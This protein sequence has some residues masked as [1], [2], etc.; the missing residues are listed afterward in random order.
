MIFVHSADRTGPSEDE[1]NFYRRTRSI[2][3]ALNWIGFEI[4]RG[5]QSKT[6]PGSSQIGKV[7]FD[8][9]SYRFQVS[10]QILSSFVSASS[11]WDR[12]RRS[13]PKKKKNIFLP[14]IGTISID[15]TPTKSWTTE[16]K[17]T[18][19][20]PKLGLSV[21]ELF[22]PSQWKRFV[23][24]LLISISVV[25]AERFFFSIRTN[26]RENLLI[27]RGKDRFC[28]REGKKCKGIE[29]RR[30][31]TKNNSSLT[32]PIRAFSKWR[33]T[34][35]E[36]GAL[37]RSFSLFYEHFSK[38][39]NRFS[40]RS[41]FVN[42]RKKEERSSSHLLLWAIRR[43]N[44]ERC[45]TLF[46][47]NG[48]SVEFF[49]QV[50]KFGSLGRSILSVRSFRMKANSKIWNRNSFHRKSTMNFSIFCLLQDSIRCIDKE[51]FSVSFSQKGTKE[52]V[53]VRLVRLR[54]MYDC[55]HSAAR[56]IVFP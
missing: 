14:R 22:H 33:L 10:K 13:W 21:D 7:N 49:S 45:F 44:D 18:R 24:F 34:K 36:F 2:P 53:W 39:F 15:E 29:G 37:Q 48:S 40:V 12:R 43:S 51:M 32:L 9:Q 17:Q 28:F 35:A 52:K 38:F 11:S 8:F 30:H 56:S 5:N 41:F 19:K 50:E 54:S 27:S 23:T 26:P 31:R 46:F 6:F 55:V 47:C 42:E 16:I 3:N 4:D 25:F 20:T 1:E